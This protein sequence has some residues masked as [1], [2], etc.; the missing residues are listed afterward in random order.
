MF[1]GWGAEGGA[2]EG[3]GWAGGCEW[4][5]RWVEVRVYGVEARSKRGVSWVGEWWGKVGGSTNEEREK[6]VASMSSRLE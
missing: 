4:G 5:G 1:E 6:Q 2:A 3:E